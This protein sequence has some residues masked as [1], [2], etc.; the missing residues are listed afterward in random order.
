MNSTSRESSATVQVAFDFG[1]DID[2][3]QSKI[4]QVVSGLADRLPDGVEPKVVVGST[5]DLPV[6]QLAAASDK[7]QQRL[8]E[9]L[10]TH[11]VPTLTGIEGVKEASVT[12]TRD[13]VITITPDADELKK[14]GLDTSAISTAIQGAGQP[15]PAGSLT[16]ADT[17]L[18]VQVGGRFE[19]IKD[20]KDLYLAPAAQASQPQAQAQ[21]ASQDQLPGS[22]QAAP[23]TAKAEK[24]KPV[25]LGDVATVKLGLAEST[26][27]TRTDGKPSLGVSITMKPGGNAVS[28]SEDVR[29]K[30]P[31]LATALGTDAALTIVYDQAPEV[32]KSI[33]SLTTEGC[34][35]WPW[36]C[37]SSWSS[38]SRYAP[39]WS[40]RS[41]SRCRC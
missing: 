23:T 21:P 20:L 17:T 16:H 8:A 28:I 33:E 25:R 2:D 5:D 37:W 10:S 39:P 34:W 14:K 7:S 36:P 40:P 22:P 38:C 32:E 9:Q 4:Q 27:L 26:T 24:P 30:L 15:I 18:S 1:T 3:A 12:G 13:Q 31:A 19:S 35:A 41:R 6:I 11:V 29:A